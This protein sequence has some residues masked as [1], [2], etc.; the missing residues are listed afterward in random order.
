MEFASNGGRKVAL[1]TPT[2]GPN[3]AQADGYIQ[4]GNIYLSKKDYD[5]AISCFNKAV[6]LKPNYG[7]DWYARAYNDRG[8]AYAGKK[9]YEDAIS[10]YTWAIN[11]SGPSFAWAYVNRGAVHFKKRDYDKAIND[12]NVAL[13]SD[14]NF[15]PA[16]YN[17][18]L[19]YKAQGKITEAQVDFNKAKQQ[20]YTGPLYGQQ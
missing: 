4:R 18:A 9:D 1:A 12:Y 20:G 13:E 11:L 14:P 6:S 17:R 3:D 2:P 5:N 15:G 16:L 8:N 7:S 10:N 19:A